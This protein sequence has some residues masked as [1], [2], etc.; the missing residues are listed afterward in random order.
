MSNKNNATKSDASQEEIIVRLFER[1]DSERIMD[2][3]FSM[4]GVRIYKW[5]DGKLVKGKEYYDDEDFSSEEKKEI[6]EKFGPYPSGRHW[7]KCGAFAGDVMVGF[8]VMFLYPSE[9]HMWGISYS[10]VSRKYQRQGIATRM[11]ALAKTTVLEA[12]ARKICF[13]SAINESAVDFY[14]SVGFTP[15][16]KPPEDERWSEWDGE[17]I[18]MEMM[19]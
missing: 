16:E 19:L 15:F 11:F 4:K 18:Y 3:D 1:G 7:V 6:V 17:D 14:L 8:L 12:G 2:V 13:L 9:Q 10:F 5:L